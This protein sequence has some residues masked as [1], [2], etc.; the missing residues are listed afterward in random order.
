MTKSLAKG[1]CH[2]ADSLPRVEFLT[3]LYP[4]R[5]MKQ[6]VANLYAYIIRFLIRAQSWYQ[7]SKPLHALHSF[8]RPAELRYADLIED[9]EACTRTV[10]SLASAGAQAEQRDM[11]LKLQAL[12]DR[13]GA[14]ELLLREMYEKLIS[15]PTFQVMAT[16]L[17]AH[18]SVS[19]CQ[20]KC[21]SRHKSATFRSSALANSGCHIKWCRAKCSTKSQICCSHGV[22][23]SAICVCKT[24]GI[25]FLAGR[26]IYFLEINSNLFTYNDTRCKLQSFRHSKLLRKE[27]LPSPEKLDACGLGTQEDRVTPSRNLLSSGPYKRPH[28]SGNADQYRYPA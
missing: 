20:F 26:E 13:Q 4:T 5:R 19:V 11:H 25:P 1:L 12:I 6:A 10:D 9:I 8:T 22:Q 15:K 28:I 23:T 3:L 17:T 21:S 7:E 16:M 18:H 14:F 27:H 2:V 24:L